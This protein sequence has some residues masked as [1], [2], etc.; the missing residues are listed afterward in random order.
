[1]SHAQ[2]FRLILL[3]LVL[4]IF[5]AGL[6]QFQLWFISIGIFLGLTFYVF[7][8]F[9]VLCLS[10]FFLTL[11]VFSFRIEA[12][13]KE[14]Y[15]SEFHYKKIKIQGS[16]DSFIDQREK[17]NRFY[18]RVQKLE[19]R[20]ETLETRARILV[21]VKPDE[22]FLYGQNLELVGTVKAPPEFQEFDYAGFLR[23]H[24]VQSLI[25]FPK[26]EPQ[27]A[28][29]TFWGFTQNL[30]NKLSEN[31]KSQLPDPH[32]SIAMGVLVGVKNQLP[33]STQ[34]DFK[35]SG[36]QHL[37]VV[38]GTNVSIILLVLG[39]FLKRFGAIIFLV[40]SLIFLMVYVGMSGAEAPVIRAAVMGGIV[41]FAL[42]LGR[43]A[44]YRNLL[45]ITAVIMGIY[46]PLML[47]KD[48]GF[49]LSFAATIGILLLLPVVQ[50][51]L[52]KCPDPFHLTT[53]FTVSLVAQIAVFPIIV[54][55][56]GDFP[57]AGIFSNLL[58]EPVMPLIMLTS[59]LV[60]L[61]GSIPIIG[62]L[63]AIPAFVLLELLLQIA[64]LFGLFG[65]ISISSLIGWIVL[66]L[67]SVFVLWA[68]FSEHYE[69]RCG[70]F[71]VEFQS[72][73]S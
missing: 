50:P 14:D 43:Q 48:I 19:F 25:R 57:W 40:V 67:L 21:M 15:L 65:V 70:E 66:F 11:G 47:S 6:L 61:F 8:K 5:A 28:G 16:V 20:G 42:V 23:R 12:Q 62:E 9:S 17:N 63:I 52:S 58:A 54:I 36:L 7:Q 73:K 59:F 56:F 68:L 24:Q 51:W 37:L 55:F 41:G 2:K 27:E 33:E 44:D 34:F 3:M 71:V 18:F 22:Y 31:L 26:V 53:I 1:M 30:R 49:F 4:G 69:A 32:A 45:L 35:T 46:D 29:T 10:L 39:F 60:S 38:S 64:H 72:N 13:V